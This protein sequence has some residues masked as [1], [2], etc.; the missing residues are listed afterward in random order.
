MILGD[1]F[2]ELVFDP[3][4]FLNEEEIDYVRAFAKPYAVAVLFRSLLIQLRKTHPELTAER[5]K[6][7]FT[8]IARDVYWLFAKPDANE[9]A[10][11]LISIASGFLPINLVLDIDDTELEPDD[12]EPSIVK[13]VNAIFPEPRSDASFQQKKVRIVV[14]FGE[15]I[16]DTIN[17]LTKKIFTEAEVTL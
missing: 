17:K 11:Q 9:Q 15:V 14:R 7:Y 16:E 5:L 8:E 3:G 2:E 10:D 4:Q 12:D 1:E 6:T 13:F